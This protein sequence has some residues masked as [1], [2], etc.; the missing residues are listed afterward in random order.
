M[1]KLQNKFSLLFISIS[2][3]PL[4][5]TVVL[6][7]YFIYLT[8]FNSI[9][10]LELQFLS[11][12]EKEIE[13]FLDLSQG[14]LAIQLL[15]SSKVISTYDSNFRKF[16]V[17]ESIM[18][19]NKQFLEIS[20]LDYDD[21]DALGS[22]LVE[23]GKEVTK[24]IREK[25]LNSQDDILKETNN[26]KSYK[27]DNGFQLAVNQGKIVWGETEVINESTVI[28][29][30]VPIRNGDKVIIGV[31]RA[32]VDLTQIK[33][34]IASSMLGQSGYVFIANNQ[35]Q[36]IF[37]SDQLIFSKKQSND[38]LKIVELTLQGKEITI[39]DNDSDYKN[40]IGQ[41]I[42]ASSL[43]IKRLNSALVA[44]W[45]KE[46]AMGIVYSLIKQSII[47]SILTLI[48]VL[49]LSFLFAQKLVKPI[50]ILMAGSKIIGDGNFEYK[51]NIKTKDEIEELA[52]SFNTMAKSLKE[53]EELKE[54]K[55]RAEAL[56]VSLAKEVELSKVKDKFISTASH[57]LRTPISV[58][59]WLSE[60]LSSMEEKTQIK[61]AK[62]IVHDL[63]QNSAQLALIM[64]D[65]LTVSE[66]GL[67]YKPKDLK[68]IDINNLIDGELSKYVKEIGNKNL[69]INYEKKLKPFNVH[70]N[71]LAIK[72]VL[73]NLI[74]NAIT[75]SNDGALL[76]IELKETDN[77]VSFSISDEGIGIPEDEKA[78]VFQEFFRAKNS[79][80]KKN[81]GTGLGLFIV[82]TVILGH[83][84]QVGFS[85]LQ[86]K[87][88]TFW[89]R[90][91]KK[92]S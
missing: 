32:V 30:F 59:R 57:Q 10:Q 67:N 15:G 3:V 20:L 43:K 89:F 26:Y 65:M 51:I 82:K 18:K 36:I 91:N 72:K 11:Q 84:G 85:S 88:S 23:N 61:Q 6:G 74:D 22:S 66:F 33:K 41:E 5:L 25:N 27:N 16:M 14:P 17:S 50:K 45:P 35:K 78:M 37:S 9:Y 38:S 28:P 19:I 80:E 44:E 53:I 52:E 56:T 54:V 55:I 86:N 40:I 42:L 1:F 83:N 81:V 29:L 76:I 62:Q 39:F 64:G 46:D 71:E 70:G 2:L 90:L 75:Y 47:F 21:Y 24:I 48:I 8:Q 12:K 31:V 69:K 58:I 73:D 60:S 7:I 79:V 92:S 13:N 87:G 49:I 77:S 4:F 68:I 63:Y 34:I